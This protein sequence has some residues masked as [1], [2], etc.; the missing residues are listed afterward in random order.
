MSQLPIRRI[1]FA[2][3]A[4]KQ[5]HDAIVAFVEEM[6]ELQK[7]YAVAAREK[8]PRAG[9]RK[10]KIDA[11][12]AEIDAAVYRLYDLSAEEIGIVEGK[13]EESK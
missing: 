2:D 6:L 11:V 8:L 7:E 9:A 1:N 12:D 5:Q 3:A 10:W 13:T 4:E